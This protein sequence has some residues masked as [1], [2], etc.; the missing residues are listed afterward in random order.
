MLAVLLRG[1]P[2]TF[3]QILGREPAF[4]REGIV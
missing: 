4:G 1:E 3:G 2:L